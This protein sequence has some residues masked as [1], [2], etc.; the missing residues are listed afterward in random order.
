MTMDQSFTPPGI[1]LGIVR[2]IS[3]GLFGPPDEFMSQ[4]RALGAGLV[5]LYVYW[6]QVE[7]EPGC[8]DW[9][10]VDAF[11]DQLNG[12]EEV[13][14]TVCSSSPWATRHATDF[15]PPAPAKDND[16]YHRFVRAL[17]IH[18]A[19][20]V[21]YWQC[22]NEPSNL[23]LLWTGTAAEY[24]EQLTALHRA[25]RAVDP[26]AAVVL[27]GCGYDVL[28]SAESSPA[29]PLRLRGSAPWPRFLARAMEAGRYLQRGD[30]P[31]RDRRVVM[32]LAGRPCRRRVWRPS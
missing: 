17:A 24:V 11:L 31:A 28:S 8:Y 26:R 20:R 25:V 2:G 15:L 3:Y 4:L 1:R 7:P 12:D 19:G 16:T 22:N 32:D 29:R 6:G 9:R 5:R 23:G 13:W 18:C 10:V 14:V 21:Q 30:G 27:G